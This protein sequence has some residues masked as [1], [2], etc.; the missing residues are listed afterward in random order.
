M[1]KVGKKKDNI[2]GRRGGE[3]VDKVRWKSG[4]GKGREDVND[5]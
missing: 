1:G 4:K 5:L 2:M 3:T